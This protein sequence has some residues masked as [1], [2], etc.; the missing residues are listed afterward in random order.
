[1]NLAFA[2]L[3]CFALGTVQ[4]G[5]EKISIGNESASQLI[6]GFLPVNMID[7]VS[8]RESEIGSLTG[9]LQN[10]IASGQKHEQALSEITALL[11]IKGIIAA[12]RHHDI[13]CILTNLKNLCDIFGQ[14]L[15]CY[16]T[17]HWDDLAPL[18][19]QFVDT[20]AQLRNC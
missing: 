4:C 16:S 2:L 11:D 6:A 18:L 10:L 7:A 19:H 15:E 20:L 13:H 12:Q 9:R 1:M 17:Q 3:T 8:E 5:S 14:I